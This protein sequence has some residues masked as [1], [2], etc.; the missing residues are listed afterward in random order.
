MAE[1]TTSRGRTVS[2]VI[3]G[4][5]MP[6]AR[7]RG[8]L[9]ENVRDE[10]EIGFFLGILEA[11]LGNRKALPKTGDMR[12]EILANQLARELGVNLIQDFP[13]TKPVGKAGRRTAQEIMDSLGVDPASLGF[14]R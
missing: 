2:D 9:P 13:E 4:R 7:V 10:S 12:P 8:R 1:K 5:K 3:F 14:G 11:A 6:E